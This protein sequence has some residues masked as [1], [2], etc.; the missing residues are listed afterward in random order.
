M[1]RAKGKTETRGKRRRVTEAC[2]PACHS[3]DLDCLRFCLLRSFL[4]FLLHS[5][6]AEGLF[7]LLSAFIGRWLDW[8]STGTW[9]VCVCVCVC[10]CVKERKREKTGRE[11][12]SVFKLPSP[13]PLE[14]LAGTG[15]GPLRRP[16][17]LWMDSIAACM[18]VR[19]AAFYG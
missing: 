5:F 17:L 9:L 18:H 14:F 6:L 13:F 11:C 10:V 15:M 8:S 19:L 12:A 4:P 2:L 7:D 16:E 3:V 1:S